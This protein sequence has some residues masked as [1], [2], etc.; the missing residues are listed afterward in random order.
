MPLEPAPPS[1]AQNPLYWGY[2]WGT[3]ASLP[4]SG[5]QSF[6]RS[7]SETED[8][9]DVFSEES[10]K[11]PCS[12]PGDAD[13]CQMLSRKK[14]RG[15]I[16]K[17]RRDRINTSLS[18]LRRLVP[19]A[20]EKQGS[21]KLEKAEI[22]QMTVDHLKVLHAKGMNALAYDPGKFAVDYHN[23]GF[24]EC[25]AEVARYLVTVEG[26]DIQDPLRMRLMSH[27]HGYAAQK[28]LASKQSP[29]Y[30]SGPPPGSNVASNT[31]QPYHQSSSPLS[32]IGS[33]HHLHRPPPP[34][35]PI[36]IPPPPSGLSLHN[37]SLNSSSGSSSL[38][39]SSLGMNSSHT[40]SSSNTSHSLNSSYDNQT[41]LE[42]SPS[43][44]A[45]SSS[46][47]N[48]TITPLVTVSSSSMDSYNY[49]H[50]NVH[51]H[52][53]MDLYHHPQHMQ[54]HPYNQGGH[55]SAV[56]KPYRPWGAEVAY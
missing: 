17:R 44:V 30:P 11:E 19:T 22:L 40:M 29:W 8:C 28:E 36:P 1:D 47:S 55:D 41:T 10:N 48:T 5:R 26:L 16:E 34:P 31:S 14:R 45:P 23:M 18:E 56:S 24:Q 3:S 52:P 13:S 7:H 2:P 39:S 49:L 53:T 51:Q 9:D 33:S 20:Y 50:H 37:T 32:P 6:K 15:I 35:I 46:S 25:A 4:P 54:Q 21:A 27:L 43:A 38:N 12:S 42:G